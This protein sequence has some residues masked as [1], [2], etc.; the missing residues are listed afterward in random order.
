MRER[1]R[2]ERKK[3]EG[4]ELTLLFLKTTVP[5]WI[6][7]AF[8]DGSLHVTSRFA[9]RLLCCSREFCFLPCWTAS[10]VPMMAG[11][12]AMEV[13]IPRGMMDIQNTE[14]DLIV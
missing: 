14:N 1:I 9:F 7:R 13:I 11:Q 6:S 2:K 3:G 4:E 5:P 8:R 12:A 10:V